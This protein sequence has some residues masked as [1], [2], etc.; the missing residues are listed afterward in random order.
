MRGERESE[1]EREIAQGDDVRRK[2]EKETE[3]WRKRV[4]DRVRKRDN[5]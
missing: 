5:E 2:R 1:K 4:R 3:Q